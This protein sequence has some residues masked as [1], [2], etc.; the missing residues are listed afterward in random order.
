MYDMKHEYWPLSEQET[1]YRNSKQP[2]ISLY[3][4]SSN[5][6]ILLLRRSARDNQVSP[7]ELFQIWGAPRFNSS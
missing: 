2:R 5:L 6:V 1:L 3:H 4:P 7:S